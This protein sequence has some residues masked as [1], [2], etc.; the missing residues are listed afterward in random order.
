MI[1]NIE[2]S[3]LLGVVIEEFKN[4]DLINIKQFDIFFGSKPYDEIIE[5][6]KSNSSQIHLFS[7][8]C[9]HNIVLSIYKGQL[10]TPKGCG[11]A[12]M[13][14]FNNCTRGH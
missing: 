10:P 6:M 5:A 8:L 12:M 3:R 1:S 7:D 11:H 14:A 4:R 2:A 13:A 9:A